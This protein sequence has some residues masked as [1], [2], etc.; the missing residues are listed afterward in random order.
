MSAPEPLR[1]QEP[2]SVEE[3]ATIMDCSEE[4]I[5]RHIEV[6]D[7]PA[8]KWGRGWRIP[9]AAFM[10]RLNQLALQLADERRAAAQQPAVAQA[11]SRAARA[12]IVT[13]IQR[14]RTRRQ[15]PRLPDLSGLTT[16]AQP[17]PRP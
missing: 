4:I 3:A 8:V 7:V 13:P 11:T 12:T 17:G 15:P 16:S 9:R 5:V 10:D 6:G 1:T 14:G 2:L